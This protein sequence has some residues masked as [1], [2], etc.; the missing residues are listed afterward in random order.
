MYSARLNLVNDQTELATELANVEEHTGLARALGQPADTEEQ[1]V[2]LVPQ[3]KMTD[4]DVEL[5]HANLN[6]H[7]IVQQSIC[8]QF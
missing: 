2:N 4:V 5:I 7:K 6:F 1:I 8:F 3:Y